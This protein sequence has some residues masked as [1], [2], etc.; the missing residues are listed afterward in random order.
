MR[1]AIIRTGIMSV[2][3]LAASAAVALAGPS[4]GWQSDHNG[5]QY[6]NHGWHSGHHGNQNDNNGHQSDHHGRR[7]NDGGHCHKPSEAPV[8]DG[9]PFL[10]FAGGLYGTYALT[11]YRNKSK[12]N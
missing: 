12:K 6:G 2:L 9:L 8:T 1:A 11:K 4:N 7:D 3:F 10:A 5:N